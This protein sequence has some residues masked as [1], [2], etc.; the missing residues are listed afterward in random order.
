[1]INGRIGILRIE[2]GAI[3][4]TMANETVS[5]R[6]IRVSQIYCPGHFSREGS[7]RR[8]WEKR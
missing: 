5:R 3:K 1:M 2:Q 7:I 8:Y 4:K 6:V